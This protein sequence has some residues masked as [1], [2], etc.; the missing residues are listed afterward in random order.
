M[1]KVDF[2]SAV[3]EKQ[4]YIEFKLDNFPEKPNKKLL[5]QL[6][7]LYERNKRSGNA[8]TK[9]RGEVEGAT[10]KPWRQKGL[11]RARVGTIRSPIWRHGGIVFGPRPR[12]FYVKIPVKMKR[13]GLKHALL[14]K[15]NDNEIKVIEN[16]NPET[17]K[18]KVVNGILKKVNLPGKLLIC[19]GG[20]DKKLLLSV[21]NLPKVSLI[22]CNEV[23]SYELLRHK[24][25]LFTMEGFEK[26]FH[27]GKDEFTVKK[28]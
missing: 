13:S 26:L 27:L 19:T 23:N 18:T 25:C 17:P 22:C 8:S 1:Y 28:N 5:H 16:L 6:V 24:Y 15:L 14:G 2:F 12:N 20:L 7:I 10:K 4:G 9:T 21:R 3:G 11:G